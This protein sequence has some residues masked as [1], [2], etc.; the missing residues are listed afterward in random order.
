MVNLGY[1]LITAGCLAGA[2]V[3]VLHKEGVPWGPWAAAV[4]VGVVGVAL[5]RLGGR[6]AA[7]SEERLTGDLEIL[8]TSLAR[9]VA[10]LETLVHEQAKVNVYEVRHL[11]DDGFMEDLNSFV[12]ARESLSHRFGVQTYA[13]VMT[14]FASGERALNRAWSASTDGYVDA[15]ARALEKALGQFREAQQQLMALS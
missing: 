9:V 10:K 2:Y 11:I 4:V 12:Q 13:N 6:K 15:V 3:A 7:T 14:S 8:G 5:A 1:L